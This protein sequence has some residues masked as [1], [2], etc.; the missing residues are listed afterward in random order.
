MK[1]AP[2]GVAMAINLN[3]ENSPDAAACDA[4]GKP[5]APIW[6][7]TESEYIRDSL[8]KVL[9]HQTKCRADAVECLKFYFNKDGAIDLE[10]LKNWLSKN[11][12]LDRW[13]FVHLIEVAGRRFLDQSFSAHKAEI[14]RSK[15]AAPRKFVLGEWT[16]RP[17]AGQSKAA[18]SRQFAPLVK[19]HFDLSVTPETIARAWLPKDKG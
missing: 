17:D 2:E 11:Q 7:A 10:F 4:N 1:A 18:F 15:N 14:A 8:K 13:F 6:G 12:P 3:F 9:S 19:R 5:V 16:N